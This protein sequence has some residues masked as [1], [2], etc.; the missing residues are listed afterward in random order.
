MMNVVGFTSGFIGIII[1]LL[2][3]IPVNLI[4]YA[5]TEISGIATLPFAGAV[6][7]IVIS[8]VLT[9]VAGI[10]PAMIAAKRDPVTSLRSE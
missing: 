9:L 1:T 8:T 7:L 5:L 3:T 10:F 4:L 2:L 6:I